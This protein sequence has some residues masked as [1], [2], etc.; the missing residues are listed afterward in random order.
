LSVINFFTGRESPLRK[1][2]HDFDLEEAQQSMA[3]LKGEPNFL[4]FIKFRELQREEVIRQLQTPEVIESVNRHFMLTGKL[5]G[6]D[7]E[8]DF[9]ANLG[10]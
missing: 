6:I 8:L 7:E 5:E 3:Q 4:E 2:Y 1:T 9:I 10:Q